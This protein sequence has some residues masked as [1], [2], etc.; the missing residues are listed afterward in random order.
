MTD[1]KERARARRE[2]EAF[3]RSR[4]TVTMDDYKRSVET[5]LSL[6]MTGTDGGQAAAQVLLSAYNS[7]IFRLALTDLCSLDLT[8]LEHALIVIRGR[9]LLFEEPHNVIDNGNDR[10]SALKEMW[11][12][13]RTAAN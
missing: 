8:N 4:L 6:G 7:K 13:L 11:P 12:D 9:I 2:E 1:H 5:L 3:L 10:F